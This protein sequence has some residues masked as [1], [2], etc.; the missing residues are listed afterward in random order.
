MA[1]SAPA[2]VTIVS[3]RTA[4]ARIDSGSSSAGTSGEPSASRHTRTVLSSPP[5]TITGVPSGRHR[6]HRAVVAAQ[7]LPDGGA[8]AR[9]SDLQR[10][11][12]YTYLAAAR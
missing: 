4:T 5:L 12:D 7:R 11:P 8:V 9:P 10:W 6:L 3:P 2:T 1:M